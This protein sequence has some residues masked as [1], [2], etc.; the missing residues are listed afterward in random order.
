[1]SIG[2]ELLRGREQE[3]YKDGLMECKKIMVL[4]EAESKKFLDDFYSVDMEDVQSVRAYGF[5]YDPRSAFEGFMDLGLIAID[6]FREI[7]GY[8]S[9]DTL[10]ATRE[11]A[12]EEFERARNV[13]KKAERCYIGNGYLPRDY[14]RLFNKYVIV[15]RKIPPSRARRDTKTTLRGKN[16]IGGATLALLML[17]LEGAPT[18]IGKRVLQCRACDKP[19]PRNSRVDHCRSCLKESGSMSELTSMKRKVYARAYR[20]G[21]TT[22]DDFAIGWKAITSL[23]ELDTYAVQWGIHAPEKQGRKPKV[24]DSKKPNESREGR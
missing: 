1:M 23:A 15:D 12:K 3:L 11:A 2:I 10:D 24:E 18:V 19:L 6:S 17:L 14:F 8:I 22:N 9:E 16:A 20:R 13:L 21:L 7:G 5:R 4:N